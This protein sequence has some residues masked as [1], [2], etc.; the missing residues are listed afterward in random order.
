MTVTEEKIDLRDEVQFLRE[1]VA[2][3]LDELKVANR[4][5]PSVPVPPIIIERPVFPVSPWY[6]TWIANPNTAQGTFASTNTL[7]FDGGLD[8][9]W[10][11]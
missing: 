10:S 1:L 8:V 11:S 6:Q 7:S 5:H 3:L 2:Q 4:R 9:R